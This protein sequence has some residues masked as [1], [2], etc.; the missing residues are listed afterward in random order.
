MVRATNSMPG[1]IGLPFPPLQ[2][3]NKG[4][5]ILSKF[6]LMMKPSGANFKMISGT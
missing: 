1:G 2:L 4:K 3:F 6:R 5:Q